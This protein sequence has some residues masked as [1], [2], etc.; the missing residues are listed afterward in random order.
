MKRLTHDLPRALVNSQR[1]HTCDNV[2]K[3][4]AGPEMTFS[5]RRAHSYRSALIGFPTWNPSESDQFM[6]RRFFH[7][8]TR[9]WT[10]H[11]IGNSQSRDTRA[12]LGTVRESL[13]HLG[14]MNGLGVIHPSAPQL[15][16]TPFL[17]H[18]DGLPTTQGSARA[19]VG[20]AYAVLRFPLHAEFLSSRRSAGPSFLVLKSDSGGVCKVRD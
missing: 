4:G 18:L 7:Q 6:R 1:V 5:R 10:T 17:G 9:M 2:T 12:L 8:L 11:G 16:T 19:S 14:Q 20:N 3:M 15:P 13:A